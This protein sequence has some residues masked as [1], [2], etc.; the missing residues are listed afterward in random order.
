MKIEP[1]TPDRWPDLEK[2]FGPGGACSGC[3]CQYWRLPHKLFDQQKG[4]ANRETLLKIVK[5]GPP[6]GLLAYQNGEPVGW[7]CLG[8][9]ED[10]PVLERSRVLKAMDDKPVWSVVCFFIA[11]AARAQGVS[12]ALLQA[13]LKYAKAQGARIVEGYPTPAR[14]GRLPDAFVYTGLESVFEQAGFVEAIRRG[15]GRA[16]W[17]Y[18]FK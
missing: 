3:W 7:I 12:K 15:K 14:Y 6:P 4:V 1:L 17:R 13:A 9:R 2:L 11:K 5:N 18:Q 16:I 8:L 10:F